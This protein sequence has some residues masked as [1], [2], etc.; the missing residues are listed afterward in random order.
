[1]AGFE[2]ADKFEKELALGILR[3]RGEKE[4]YKKS[5]QE[6]QLVY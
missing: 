6:T 1:M 3:H 5:V 4:R 2:P